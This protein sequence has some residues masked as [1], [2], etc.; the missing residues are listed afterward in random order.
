[1]GA[2]I[3]RT[4][5]NLTNPRVL[6]RPGKSSGLVLQTML[7]CSFLRLILCVCGHYF[8]RVNSLMWMI[9]D[10]ALTKEKATPGGL[11]GDFDDT[12]F[13]I[14]SLITGDGWT[15]SEQKFAFPFP[16]LPI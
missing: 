11:S 6:D 13:L 7:Q 5:H 16:T 9:Q 2:F 14:S 8:L 12:F 1:M 4:Y 15:G 10:E 3:L